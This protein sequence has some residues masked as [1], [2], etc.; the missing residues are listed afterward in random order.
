MSAEPFA[1]EPGRL[2]VDIWSDI[3]CPWCYLGDTALEHALQDFPHAERVDVR[4]RSFLLRP[5]LP[6]DRPTDL[7]ELISSNRGSSREEVDAGHA[8]LAERGRALGL[9]YRF[10]KAI[11]INS[12]S[13]H[14]L[15]HV[16]LD[17]GVQRAMMQRLFLAYFTEGRNVA[18]YD[19]LTDL[20]EEVGLDGAKT[21]SALES[22]AHLDDVQDDIALARQLGISGVPFFVFNGKYAVSGGQPVEVFKQTLD[23]VWGELSPA[24]AG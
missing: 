5:D 14:R 8:M 24:P 6:S 13:A 21:R 3:M 23:T 17:A 20:A 12:T 4:Y 1:L 18:D 9:D 19:T 7:Y 16:A 15:S 10:D 22:G 11:A 2:R